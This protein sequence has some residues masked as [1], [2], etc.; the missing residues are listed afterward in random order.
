MCMNHILVQKIRKF[1]QHKGMAE[2]QRDTGANTKLD[3]LNNKYFEITAQ[4]IK[5]L[6]TTRYESTLIYIN[7]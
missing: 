2:G 7:N 5:Q 4:S 6:D 3:H 1:S